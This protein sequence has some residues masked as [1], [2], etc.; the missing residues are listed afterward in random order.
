MLLA[1]P[2]AAVLGV[3]EAPK[4]FTVDLTVPKMPE[5]IWIED[6]TLGTG[7]TSVD[8]YAT[9]LVEIPEDA[10]DEI[11]IPRYERTTSV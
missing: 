1:A 10:G 5:R 4:E 3:P 2:V 11:R 8:I 7:P 6:I 9:W